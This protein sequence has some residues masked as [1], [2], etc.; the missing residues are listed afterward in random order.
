MGK[1]VSIHMDIPRESPAV[2]KSILN[3]AGTTYKW[4]HAKPTRNG[5]CFC[6]SGLKTK[7]CC[8]P[9]VTFHFL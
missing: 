8:G 7:L 2:K 6:G 4:N 9:K 5:P 1:S 3:G